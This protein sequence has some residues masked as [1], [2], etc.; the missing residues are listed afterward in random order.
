MWLDLAEDRWLQGATFPLAF[1]R[2][3][4]FGRSP[5]NDCPLPGHHVGRWHFL[6][7]WRGCGLWVG[8]VPGRYLLVLNGRHVPDEWTRMHVG[9]LLVAGGARL[10][11]VAASCPVSSRVLQ[12]LRAIRERGDYAA[13]PILAD[14]LEEEGFDIPEVLQH[15]REKD[16]DASC[17]VLGLQWDV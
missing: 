16:H 9:D 15:C 11:V 13:L 6:L 2:E 5:D 3:L 8:R 4:T 17:W 14:A 12:I 7:A 10:R 1:G